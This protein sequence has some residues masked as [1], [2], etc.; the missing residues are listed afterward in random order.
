MD[1]YQMQKYAA[2]AVKKLP[3][4]DLLP[5]TPDQIT[6]I[7]KSEATNIITQHYAQDDTN[8]HHLRQQ[9]KIYEMKQQCKDMYWRMNMPW[10]SSICD[11]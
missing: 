4:E 3:E 9:M 5:L 6:N 7:S 1:L 10:H 8:I 11:L 2:E